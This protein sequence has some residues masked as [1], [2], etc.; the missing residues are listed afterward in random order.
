MKSILQ[1]LL[2][3]SLRSC[4]V[5]A[6]V[7][8]LRALFSKAP[9]WTR[10]LLWGVAALSLIL[11]WRIE[12]PVSL[13][14]RGAVERVDQVFTS[15]TEQ[16]NSPS[17]LTD[18][19]QTV[20]TAEDSK[21]TEETSIPIGV[22]TATSK[23][24]V[25][26]ILLASL[27]L[28]GTAVMLLYA[29]GS[30]LK[31]RRKTAASIRENGVYYCDDISTPFV[32]GAIRPRIYLP[33]EI[34]EEE[35]KFVLAHE[36]A[37]L[38]SL[39]Q[40]F[41]SIG[42]LILSIFWFH[43]LVWAAWY[44]FDRD[45][46]MACDEAVIRELQL[47]QNARADYS[48][49]LLALSM[50]RPGLIP[51]PLAF[52]ENDVK[53]RVKEV[54]NYKKAPFWIILSVLILGAA[55][56]VCFLTIPKSGKLG[57]G[58]LPFKDTRIRPGMSREE[59]IAIL[60]E[61]DKAEGEDYD[62]AN[63]PA[64]FRYSKPIQTLFGEASEVRFQFSRIPI[65]LTEDSGR[66]E[67]EYVNGLSNILIVVPELKSVEEGEKLLKKIYGDYAG[68]K[69][70]PNVTFLRGADLSN[71]DPE[72]TEEI[73][74]MVEYVYDYAS[75]ELGSLPD[76]EYRSLTEILLAWRGGPLNMIVT[77][78][79][80]LMRIILVG[81][82]D[83]PEVG[84]KIDTSLWSVLQ[85]DP[86]Y[87]AAIPRNSVL[88]DQEIRQA[89]KC[90][91]K[92]AKETGNALNLSISTKDIAKKGPST[93]RPDSARMICGQRFGVSVD[94]VD[95]GFSDIR[96]VFQSD[97]PEAIRSM[98]NDLYS[99]CVNTYGEPATFSGIQ[100]RISDHM[101]NAEASKTYVEYWSVGEKSVCCINVSIPDG[102]GSEGMITLGYFENT[103]QIAE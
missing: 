92:K 50:N 71:E 65:S 99:L 97:D 1:T 63:P 61:P 41:K 89:E 94:F 87:A 53:S 19:G 30:Y 69:D 103:G 39:H 64:E 100:D 22:S 24:S 102:N 49:T 54:L 36:K 77:D 38:K 72:T 16:N 21:P 7:M 33:S 55:A 14:P 44:L 9:K 76:Q 46:E 10:L 6:A 8:L 78:A 51:C 91:G 29:L 17:T 79:T 88:T 47:D 3:V 96:Y 4:I 83:Q 60:G 2:W 86:I 37:H 93:A 80:N 52:G 67:L 18:N 68:K 45:L 20:Q 62:P 57:C 90:Y 5:I 56:A 40:I 43:P 85:R 34:G 81:R 27:W 73:E 66:N 58:D 23:Q 95:N 74:H 84:I 48:E 98:M 32:L 15:E 13:I 11:P 26:P 28:F 42:Y 101:G 31:L 59:L 70:G 12:S 25:L 75:W 82:D 35:K